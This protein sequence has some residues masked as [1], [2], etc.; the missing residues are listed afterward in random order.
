MER[1]RFG[2]IPLNEA[3]EG[4]PAKYSAAM[5]SLLVVVG[6]ALLAAVT[7]M[8]LGARMGSPEASHE[9]AAV[10]RKLARTLQ[11]RPLQHQ[12][13]PRSQH[14]ILHRAAPTRK[15]YQVNEAQSIP[16]ALRSPE[17]A[18]SSLLSREKT[19]TEAAGRLHTLKVLLPEDSQI[20]GKYIAELHSI[21]DFM[22]EGSGLNLSRYRMSAPAVRTFLRIN[23]LALLSVCAYQSRPAAMPH[24]YRHN[25]R[26]ASP[27]VH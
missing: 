10:G 25:I 13:A 18:P 14:L 21:L 20:E 7:A 5:E 19:L 24:S 11:H 6:V 9:L 16:F 8:F 26:Q 3:R 12:P 22:E 23:I 15:A 2:N 27:Q 17:F 4:L 1:C